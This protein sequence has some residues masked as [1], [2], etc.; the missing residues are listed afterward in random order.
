M[1]YKTQ[2]WR[3][4]TNH[5]KKKVDKIYLRNQE[6]NHNLNEKLSNETIGE[7]SHF[8]FF[9]FAYFSFISD[10]LHFLKFRII[11]ANNIHILGHFLIFASFSSTSFPIFLMV[12][13]FGYLGRTLYIFLLYFSFFLFGE[14]YSYLY[15]FIFPYFSS[16]SFLIFSFSVNSHIFG[17]QQTYLYSLFLFWLISHHH[18]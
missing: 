13:N 6:R 18:F 2:E 9:I 8:Y 5:V 11:M 3:K 16:S 12:G 15:F 17:E 1:V 10:C 4:G 7:Q 14:Q